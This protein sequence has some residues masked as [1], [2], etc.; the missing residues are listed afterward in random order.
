MR[1]KR[2]CASSGARV[3]A[4]SRQPPCI[5]CRQ[6]LHTGMPPTTCSVG[7]ALAPPSL[8]LLQRTLDAGL[9]LSLEEELRG[10]LHESIN[11]LES[12]LVEHEKN[13]KLQHEAALAELRRGD[14][15]VMDELLRKMAELNLKLGTNMQ[16]L[17]DELTADIRRALAAHT[18]SATA[19][20][21]PHSIARAALPGSTK[22]PQMLEK[23]ELAK[24]DALEHHMQSLREEMMSLAADFHRRDADVHNVLEGLAARLKPTDAE[25]AHEP[26]STAQN[27]AC[28]RGFTCDGGAD[29]DCRLE[30]VE[31][32]L[33]ATGWTLQGACAQLDELRVE[34]QKL[35]HQASMQMPKSPCRRGAVR[36]DI[37][38]SSPVSEGELQLAHLEERLEA[39]REAVRSDMT[40]FEQELQ[41][42]CAEKRPHEHPRMDELSR[43]AQKLEAHIDEMD[44]PP[45]IQLEAR[46]EALTLA[47][48]QQC[49]EWVDAALR[50]LEALALRT[51]ERCAALAAE[52]QEVRQ[53][54]GQMSQQLRGDV[55]QI[56][57]QVQSVP[58]ESKQPGD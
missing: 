23:R 57:S 19:H 28:S 11:R 47:T 1:G 30:K 42:C 37:S 10:E 16:A 15:V 3:G 38:A 5:G 34:V 4:C 50:R 41:A 55:R 24:I 44:E 12:A 21:G 25:E 9:G 6:D 48:R 39:V 26:Q 27:S 14:R 17:E 43:L 51:R 53:E 40:R 8:E 54:M 7:A 36:L 29:L 31:G 52:L 35:H 46:L 2:G 58:L 20:I 45:R 22:M 56:G 49:R 32:E 33:A 18:A 13:Q